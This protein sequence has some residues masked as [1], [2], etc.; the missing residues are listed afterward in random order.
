VVV[1]WVV[2]GLVPA[3]V[4]RRPRVIRHHVHLTTRTMP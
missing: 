3:H 2:K 4:S 1:A